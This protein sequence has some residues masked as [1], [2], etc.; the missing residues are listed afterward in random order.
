MNGKRKLSSWWEARGREASS[1]VA[2]TRRLR[3]SSLHALNSSHRVRKLSLRG[4]EAFCC[5]FCL[6]WGLKW[7]WIWQ[8]CLW[9]WWNDRCGVWP[10]DPDDLGWRNFKWRRRT[11]QVWLNIFEFCNQAEMLSSPHTWR[12]ERCRLAGSCRTKP[13]RRL[14]IVRHRDNN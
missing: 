13:V 3:K 1:A 9:A 5:C 12:F 11:N 14:S 2:D 6:F 10:W 8:T 4:K 7:N